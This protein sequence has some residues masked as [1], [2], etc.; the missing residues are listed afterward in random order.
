MPI[1]CMCPEYESNL[2][3]LI[4]LRIKYKQNKTADIETQPQIK[5]TIIG[6]KEF[7]KTH[8]E[9]EIAERLEAIRSYLRSPLRDPH[10]ALEEIFKDR[11]VKMPGLIE[12]FKEM[13][14]KKSTTE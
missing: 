4:S 8:I 2:Q 12:T 11:K 6:Q 7:L 14:H 13:L 5:E 1:L 9:T 10:M 3:E